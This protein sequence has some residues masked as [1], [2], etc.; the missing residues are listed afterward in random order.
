MSTS[1]LMDQLKTQLA[2]AYAQEFL[3]VSLLAF[4]FYFVQLQIH[5]FFDSIVFLDWVWVL[6]WLLIS[7]RV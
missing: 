7:I 6:P 3:E 4:T 2:Q 1:D 5:F